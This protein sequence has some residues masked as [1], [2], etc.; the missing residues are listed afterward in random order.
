M[1]ETKLIRQKTGSLKQYMQK[2]EKKVRTIRKEDLAC[3]FRDS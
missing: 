1:S 2:R 3:G